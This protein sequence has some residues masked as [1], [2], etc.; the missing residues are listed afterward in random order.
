MA[1]TLLLCAAP[2]EARAARALGLD[3][4]AVLVSG[5]GKVAAAATLAAH[6][7]G[8]SPAR[9]L[10]FGV[11]GCFV[12]APVQLAVGALCIVESAVLADEGL[13]VTEGF[14][15]LEDMGLGQVRWPAT[16][17]GTWAASVRDVVATPPSVVAATVSTCSGTEVR[18][19]EVR[20]VVPDA[21]IETME[22]AAWAAA[23]AAAG[24][25]VEFVELR[26]IS[27]RCGERS[28]AG[29]DLEG[30]VDVLAGAL[31]RVR[32]ADLL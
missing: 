13:A 11:A 29:W 32:E 30:A 26:A 8:H 1:R 28:Q 18:A 25:P 5:V 14:R 27:N 24:R 4:S 21:S 22:S 6:L 2:A 7:V 9:V 3:A 16:A 12:E 23:I 17:A 10:G 20:A 15:T 31:E 19:R